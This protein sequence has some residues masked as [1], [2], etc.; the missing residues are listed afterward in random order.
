MGI[1]PPSPL[2]AVLTSDV[3]QRRVL[4]ALPQLE[5]NEPD[6][7]LTR[8]CFLG[9]A[10]AGLAAFGVEAHARAVEQLIFSPGDD[11][12]QRPAPA[13][14]QVL[15]QPRQRGDIPA[16][17]WER[18]RELWMRRQGTRDEV[19]VVYWRD[20]RLLSEGYWQACALLRD[21]RANL[22][23]SIDPTIL[24]IMR[25]IAGYYEAWGWP[26]PIVATSGYR[27]VKTN[28]SL[29]KEGAAKNSMHLYG[30]AVDL[31][32]PGIPTK[33]VSALGVY[34]QQGGVGFYPDQGFTH[35]DTGKLRSWR[36]P[37]R[38]R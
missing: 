17:F 21:V 4:S 20:G 32:I 9:A 26:H 10:T 11:Q 16:D 5:F 8:R 12:G 36:G 14:E 35:L 15:R 23:T 29:S 33:D 31:Y 25:G 7:R 19:K 2:A 28:N 3:F 18:P 34:L 27:T 22:M 37:S 30:K 13:E 38:P 6:I 24:D 1:L